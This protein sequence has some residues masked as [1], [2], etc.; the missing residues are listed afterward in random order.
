MDA[1][2]SD[3][4]QAVCLTLGEGGDIQVKLPWKQEW[5]QW[6]R[7]IPG[8]KWDHDAKV[9]LIPETMEA[10]QLFYHYFQHIPVNVQTEQLFT[11]FPVL[12]RLKREGEIQSLQKLLE[13]MKRKGYSPKTQK[14]YMGAAARFLEQL[15]IP[16][17]ET[18]SQDIHSYVLGLLK[19]QRSHASVDQTISALRF[20]ICEVEGRVDFPKSWI[21][22][23]KEKKLPSVLSAAEVLKILGAVPN[24]KHRTILTLVYAGGLRIGEVVRLKKE[25]IDPD[26]KVICIR[27]GKGKKD[28]YTVLSS[29]AYRLLM[30]Y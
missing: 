27:Q 4:N 29:A 1:N 25:D 21:R 12:H 7:K 17:A 5:I 3:E 30:E 6:I 19:L 9:W 2:S 14:A 10:V 18:T 26:R 24:L 11:K 16:F 13:T 28:R 20:W 22:P 23:K 15:T 8:R